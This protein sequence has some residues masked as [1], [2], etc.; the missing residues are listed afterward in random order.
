LEGDRQHQGCTLAA[1]DRAR[2]RHCRAGQRVGGR[3]LR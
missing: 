3:R 1:D 2:R